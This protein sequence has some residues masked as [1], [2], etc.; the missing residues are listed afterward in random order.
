MISVYSCLDFYD[1]KQVDE[2]DINTSFSY[3]ISKK[4]EKLFI[5]C[6]CDYRTFDNKHIKSDSNKTFLYTGLEEKADSYIK[7]KK[8]E[9]ERHIKSHF[10]W[11]TE[12]INN[13]IIECKL[14]P[15]GKMESMKKRI[16]AIVYFFKDKTTINPMEIN[17]W[18]SVIYFLKYDDWHKK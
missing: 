17:N 16:L 14:K 3:R 11:V 6:K 15:I 4:L 13:K 10:K 8:N 1:D 2:N 9:V 12:D 7:N 18:I 5:Q